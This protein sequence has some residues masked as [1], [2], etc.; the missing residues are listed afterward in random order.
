MEELPA[1]L[2]AFLINHPFLQV[3]GGKKIKCT[4]NGHE[5]PCNLAELQ[6][7]T[8]G[9]KYE[10]LSAAAEFNYSQ[11]E[12]H[13]VQST[14]QPNQLFCKLTL[15]H[16]NRQPH[17]VLRHI[18]GKR[19]KKALSKY[20]ECLQQG[21]D[22][23]PD[24]LK[25]K[26]PKYTEEEISRGKASKHS[27]S[28]WEPSSSDEEHSDS[29]DSMSD[30]YPSSMFTLKNS[31]KESMEG[32]EDEEDDFQT[33]EDEEMEVDKQVMQKRKK[34]QGGGFQKKFRN[35][36]CKSGRKKGGKVQNGK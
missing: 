9:K 31:G 4:L 34:V 11:Y 18:N 36:R 7:F 30:L 22:F 32:K 20:E 10:K 33:D 23:V 2:R 21:I 35:N 15:R 16:L 19:F 29:E 27:N 12:P 6:N 1:D 5:F 26:R 8:Q 24:R 3:T 14:K 17:H 13:I 28:T 25:Q